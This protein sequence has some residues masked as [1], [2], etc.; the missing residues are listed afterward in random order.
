MF[1][2]TQSPQNSLPRP[3]SGSCK[4]VLGVKIQMFRNIL[5]TKTLAELLSERE[6]IAG[7]LKVGASSRYGMVGRIYVDRLLFR[8]WSILPQTHGVLTLNEWR[9]HW[10]VTANVKYCNWTGF[11]FLI[12]V[13]DV[14]L[15]QNLQRA[16]AAEA[17]ATREARAKVII[18]T[19]LV[20]WTI[21]II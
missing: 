8:P 7:G 6:A 2:I 3:P 12:Q 15:P 5:G 19:N 9:W 21:E 17:E 13:K 14:R 16:M 20:I 11:D 18:L 4:N 10:S 1:L